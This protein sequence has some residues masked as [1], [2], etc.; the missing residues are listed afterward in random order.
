M[1]NLESKLFDLRDEIDR[2]LYTFEKADYVADDLHN[3]FSTVVHDE[4]TERMILQQF[5]SKRLAVFILC[6]Y[7]N[8]LEKKIK[9]I[10]AVA[11]ELYK[12][13]AATPGDT[14]Q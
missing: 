3:Y 1:K 14:A 8:I 9:D 13:T 2:A 4:L 7:L 12:K 6:D 5:G 11:D 10:R